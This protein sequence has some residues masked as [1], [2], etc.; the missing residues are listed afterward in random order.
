MV[1]ENCDPVW[2]VISRSSDV[3]FR[4]AAP[5]LFIMCYWNNADRGSGVA[6]VKSKVG[7]V[8]GGF[9]NFVWGAHGVCEPIAGVWG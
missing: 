4:T 5:C 8:G 9:R 6:W 3:S 2:Y 1:C 7:L